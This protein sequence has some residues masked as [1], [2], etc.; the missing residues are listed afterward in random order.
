MCKWFFRDATKIQNGRQRSTLINVVGAKILKLKVR[1]YSNFTITFPTI[2][3]YAWDFFKVLLIFN[4]AA[5]DKLHIFCGRKNWKIE[6]IN[7]SHCTITSPTIW[8]MCMWFYWNSKWPP[9]IDFLNI[10]DRKKSKLIYGGGWS[11]CWYV[12]YFQVDNG[13]VKIFLIL[14]QYEMS[15]RRRWWCYGVVSN[16]THNT[17]RG[18]SCA[19]WGIWTLTYFWLRT[20]TYLDVLMHTSFP[21]QISKSIGPITV[22]LHIHVL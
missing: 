13:Q 21:E 17:S 12:G 7:N 9:Q 22:I 14:I 5:M 11:S 4:M 8:K 10:C 16:F 19:F 2:W 18:S 1:N 6:I 15:Q 20:M 3:R